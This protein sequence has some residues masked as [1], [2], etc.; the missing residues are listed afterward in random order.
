[1]EYTTV[2]FGRC[3]GHQFVASDDSPIIHVQWDGTY[4]TAILGKIV[5]SEIPESMKNIVLPEYPCVMEFVDGGGKTRTSVK[6]AMAVLNETLT[7][8]QEFQTYQERCYYEGKWDWSNNWTA[9]YKL[10]QWKF[11]ERFA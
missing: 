1:M 6:R 2:S 3:N 8:G 11:Q 5:N 4:H 7:N 9:A 10:L